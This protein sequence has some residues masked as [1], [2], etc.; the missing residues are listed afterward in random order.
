M[1][2]EQHQKISDE[3]EPKT[4]Y[5]RFLRPGSEENMCYTQ[6]KLYIQN[7][8]TVWNKTVWFWVVTVDINTYMYGEMLPASQ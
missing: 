7:V 8:E 6:I 1:Q 2:L 5:W 4:L 3:P